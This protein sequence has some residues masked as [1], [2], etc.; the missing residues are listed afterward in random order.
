[1]RRDRV[2]FG[3][4][5]V[6]FGFIILAIVQYEVIL[7]PSMA[8]IDEL[9]FGVLLIFSGICVVTVGLIQKEWEYD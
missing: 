6:I 9:F 1:M 2:I 5:V 7:R 3:I 4:W 8:L